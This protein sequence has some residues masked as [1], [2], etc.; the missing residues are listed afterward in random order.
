MLLPHA[1]EML[2]Q[3]ACVTGVDDSTIAVCCRWGFASMPASGVYPLNANYA[4]H[5]APQ[6]SS[7]LIDFCWQQLQQQYGGALPDELKLFAGNCPALLCTYAAEYHHNFDAASSSLSLHQLITRCDRKWLVEVGFLTGVMSAMHVASS[8]HSSMLAL[9]AE[10]PASLPLHDTYRSVLHALMAPAGYLGGSWCK[11]LR[12]GTY[13]QA[14]GPFW[15]SA[16]SSS[17]LPPPGGRG[18]PWLLGSPPPTE[19]P[20]GLMGCMHRTWNMRMPKMTIRLTHRR[21]M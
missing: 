13:L 4:L 8:Y 18:G 17:G 9:F 21:I 1:L 10:M 19:S 16:L 3:K 11:R 5:V 2:V 15:E 12:F 14:S 7:S 6:V 20:Y